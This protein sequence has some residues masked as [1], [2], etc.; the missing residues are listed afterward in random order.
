MG[1][2]KKY[3][4]YWPYYMAMDTIYSYYNIC[5]DLRPVM[6][7]LSQVTHTLL[8]YVQHCM[9]ISIMYAP[10]VTPSKCIVK[11]NKSLESNGIRNYHIREALIL[12]SVMVSDIHVLTYK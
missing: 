6:T 1:N 11:L 12:R 4:K 9:I 2:T 3:E 7:H 10:G 5:F 8:T